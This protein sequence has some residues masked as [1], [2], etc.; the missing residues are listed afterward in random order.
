M[1]I[2]RIVILLLVAIVSFVSGALY[3][4]FSTWNTLLGPLAICTSALVATTLAVKNIEQSKHHEIIKRTLDVINKKPDSSMELAYFRNRINHRI[5]SQKLYEKEITL[6][7]L[8]PIIQSLKKGEGT[9][10]RVWLTYVSNM[11]IGIEE[12]IYDREVIEKNLGT[13]PIN[14]WR[15][16]WPVAKWQELNIQQANGSNKFEGNSEYRGIETW[17]K[18]LTKR[19]ITRERPV[20]CYQPLDDDTHNKLLNKGK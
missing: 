9:I 20:H 14:V 2:G 10:A 5:H 12:G 3:G 17:V 4:D 7:L 1:S 13:L 11:Y 16:F 6:D 8:H 19:D 15:D 18:E